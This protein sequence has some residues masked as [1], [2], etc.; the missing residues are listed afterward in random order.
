MEPLPFFGGELR[1]YRG[2]RQ[3]FAPH[4]HGFYVLSIVREGT[5]QLICNGDRCTIGPGQ[6]LVLNPGDVHSCEQ[7]DGGVFTYDSLTIHRRLLDNMRLEA[8]PADGNG[9]PHVITDSS[10]MASMERML[11]LAAADDDGELAKEAALELA[12]R[13]AIREIEGQTA[14]SKA[15]EAA[16]RVRSRLEADISQP[17]KLGELA[18]AEGLSEYALIRAYSREYSITPLQHL[19]S[20]RVEEACA[21]LARGMAPGAVA[22]CLG[23]SDQAHLTRVFK[24]RTALTP[25]AYASMRS[26]GKDGL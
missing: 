8:S 3:P 24:A 22:A 5:R 6:G 12:H 13:L 17:M 23:F 18:A 16:R 10:L 25:G 19:L 7:D 9:N 11:Q 4:A 15:R 2:I 1:L 20:L 14:A 26:Q 21:L